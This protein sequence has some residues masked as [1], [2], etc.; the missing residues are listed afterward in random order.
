MIIDEGMNLEDLAYCLSATESVTDDEVAKVH[1]MLV[2]EFDGMDIA[3]V[4][5]AAWDRI[6]EAL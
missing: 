2:E 4:P 1:A 3:D 5:L 6:L